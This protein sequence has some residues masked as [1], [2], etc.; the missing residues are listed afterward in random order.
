MT[1][2][3][4]FIEHHTKAHRLHEGPFTG[5]ELS[6]GFTSEAEEEAAVQEESDSFRE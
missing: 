5:K 1:A 2:S 4:E 3:K 6:D